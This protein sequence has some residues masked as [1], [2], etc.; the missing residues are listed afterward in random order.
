MSVLLLSPDKYEGWFRKD[1]RHKSMRGPWTFNPEGNSQKSLLFRYNNICS[2]IT[3][4]G[5]LTGN[6]GRIYSGKESCTWTSG[7]SPGCRPG[8]LN[9]RVTEGG[10]RMVGAAPDWSQALIMSFLTV[11]RQAFR[12]TVSKG[13]GKGWRLWPWCL[14]H[15]PGKYW[16][17]CKRGGTGENTQQEIQP[18]CGRRCEEQGR[19]V[20]GGAGCQSSASVERIPR[21]WSRGLSGCNKLFMLEKKTMIWRRCE[22]IRGSGC[23][24][25]VPIRM[26]WCWTSFVREG[27]SMEASGWS[28]KQSVLALKE[29]KQSGL[30]VKALLQLAT[31]FLRR[32][33]LA[34][35]R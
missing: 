16:H 28:L 6:L 7:K 12:S 21:M 33:N 20:P 34:T 30:Q 35:T 22:K 25:G 3:Q 27:D 2:N 1:I 15:W 10:L 14:T 23:F 19:K 4:S 11:G 18:S 13:P 9:R 17:V 8:F 24:P 26:E 32:E 5:L 29:G 31:K